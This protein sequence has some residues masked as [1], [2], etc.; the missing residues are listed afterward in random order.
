[1]KTKGIIMPGGKSFIHLIRSKRAGKPYDVKLYVETM[2]RIMRNVIQTFRGPFSGRSDV[3]IDPESFLNACWAKLEDDNLALK[4][5]D[6]SFENDIHLKRYIR[7]TFENLLRE[8]IN[9]FTPGL[10]ARR[11]QVER[12]M[13]HKCLS[14]C[15]KICR[16]WKLTEF[17]DQICTPADRERLLEAAAAFSTPQLQFPKNPDSRSPSLKDSEMSHYLTSILRAVG[18]MARHEDILHLLISR[19][20][21]VTIRMDPEASGADE[22]GPQ[23]EGDFLLSPDHE[24]IAKDLV[25]RMTSDMKD[26]HYYRV[27]REMTIEETAK[28]M[29]KSAGTVFNREKSYQEFFAKYFESK[30]EFMA[31]EETEAIIRLVSRRVAEMK[32]QS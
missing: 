3:G 19:F 30:G 29:G 24:L 28:A 5:A 25:G 7:R 11:K 18:G 20:N 22:A 6:I 10:R 4:L 21:F 32:E 9:E 14:T 2:D 16:C 27:V 1:M 31:F 23:V 8:M 17:R 13:K 26:I 15:R 12:V